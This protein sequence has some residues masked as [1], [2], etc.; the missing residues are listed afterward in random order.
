MYI[1]F[2]QFMNAK[3]I[4]ISKTTKLTKFKLHS[5]HGFAKASLAF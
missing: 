2:V 5:D 1:A 3:Q 4:Y